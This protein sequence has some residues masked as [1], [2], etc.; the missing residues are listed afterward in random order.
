MVPLSYLMADKINFKTENSVATLQL[1]NPEKLNALTPEM[2]RG[3]DEHLDT[4]DEEENIYVIVITGTGTK[5]FSS[6]LDISEFSGSIDES[7]NLYNETMEKI[8]RFAYPTIA[9]IN[10]DA[11][12]GGI[13]LATCCDVRIS[14]ND[15]QFALTPAKLGIIYIERG[16]KQL[17]DIIG[18][19][20]TKE[21][22][23]TAEHFSAEQAYEMGLINR[24]AE[25]KKLEE[26]TYDIANEI[27]SKAPLSLKGTK[28]LVQAILDKRKFST[29]ELQWIRQLKL[30]ARESE[31][32][33]EGLE[34]ISE[35]RSPEFKGR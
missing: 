3:I 35:K 4:I 15:C 20:K 14:A 2:L 29:G 34:A 18:P 32:H 1:N 21:M 5:S 24:V 28:L 23:Y 31:D 19:S 17:V 10:G 11:I 25:R 22:I 7:Q 9:M 30:E 13:D 12:G 16:L 26:T 8:Q 6:G 33:K 27:S